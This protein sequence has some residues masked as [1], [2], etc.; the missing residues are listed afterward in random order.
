MRLG[1]DSYSKHCCG[2]LPHAYL[3]HHRL[4]Q[5]AL[6]AAAL[7]CRWREPL[8]WP[9]PRPQSWPEAQP[10]PPAVR[11]GQVRPA[12]RQL[13]L[14]VPPCAGPPWA[15][16]VRL[17]AARPQAAAHSHSGAARQPGRPVVPTSPP[18]QLQQQAG[19]E[20]HAG[21][22]SSSSSSRQ[23]STTLANPCCK[24]KQPMQEQTSMQ[25]H[26]VLQN[27]I[28]CRCTYAACTLRSTRL[29]LQRLTFFLVVGAAE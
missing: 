3:L 27:E 17:P 7:L 19:Q 16:P 9:C 11:P 23:S 10:G 18:Q 15:Q 22:S 5:S 4:L 6:P 26:P 8:P 25:D 1:K 24:Q 28:R 14:P 29:L 13:L 20:G 2:C 12:A 21:S